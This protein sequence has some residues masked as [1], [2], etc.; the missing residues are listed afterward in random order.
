[1]PKDYLILIGAPKCGTTTIA[2]WLGDQPDA[3][4]ARQKE[5]RYFT[6]FASRDWHGPAS[7]F[8]DATPE[9]PEAFEAEFAAA[10][11]ASLRIEASTDNLS[12]KGAAENIARFAE[13][14]DVGNLWIVALLRDPVARIV[15]EYEHTLRFGWQS[16]S[17]MQ[18]LQ[19]EPKR[20]LKGWHPLFWHLERSR[21]GEQLARYRELFGERLLILDFHRIGE[22]EERAK[23]MRMIDREGV[24]VAQQLTHRNKREVVARP[25]AMRLAHNKTLLSLGRALVPQMMRPLARRLMTGPQI[26]RYQP[27]AAERAFIH[28]ALGEDI[29]ACVAA[30]DIPTQ[31]WDFAVPADR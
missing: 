26:D 18:S 30:P 7:N 1:M 4:L 6:D 13:R 31:H 9:S 21:Y 12:C 28:D 11:E 5:T 22:A 27:S 20:R 8:A 3:V 24:P 15:S 10:P 14:P 19:A 17:L 25:M 16:G 23:L 2:S 29:A